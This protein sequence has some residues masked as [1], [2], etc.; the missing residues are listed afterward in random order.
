MTVP[1]LPVPVSKA[2]ILEEE[3]ERSVLPKKPLTRKEIK[4]CRGY[5]R[6]ESQGDMS[7]E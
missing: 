4:T 1:V 2:T 5:P 3:E 6:G 7:L